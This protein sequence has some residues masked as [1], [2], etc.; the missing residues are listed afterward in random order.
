M[1]GWWGVSHQMVLDDSRH[2][3]AL[4]KKS[5]SRSREL[6]E[7]KREEA[8]CERLAAEGPRFVVRYDLRDTGRSTTYEP[9]ASPYTLPDLADDAVGLL[10]ALKVTK[11]HLVGFSLGG[12]SAN[13]L[14][15]SILAGSPR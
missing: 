7:C 6:R 14:P 10:D 11:A 12:V 15:L 9:G 8:F 2:S 4:A 5:G 3:T 1:V 13:A